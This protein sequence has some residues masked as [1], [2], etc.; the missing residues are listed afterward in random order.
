MK[1]VLL[2]LNTYIQ[3]FSL[4]YEVRD[5]NDEVVEPPDFDTND[6]SLNTLQT[7]SIVIYNSNILY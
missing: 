5:A 7:H 4:S 6:A 2:N 3:A 1:A